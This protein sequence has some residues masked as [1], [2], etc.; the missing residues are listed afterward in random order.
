MLV[1][2]GLT[3]PMQPAR[4]HPPAAWPSG[5]STLGHPVPDQRCQGSTA[6]LH[7]L[8]HGFHATSWGAKTHVVFNK[9]KNGRSTVPCTED[10]FPLVI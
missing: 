7:R 6:S 2:Q 1:Y 4:F 3:P 10:P 8:R 9:G 5:R